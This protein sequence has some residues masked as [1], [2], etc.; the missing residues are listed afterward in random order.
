MVNK[1]SMN[2]YQPDFVTPPGETLLEVLESLTMT[3]TE[4]AER[5]GRPTKT[6]NEIIKGK[7]AL[8]PETALQFEKVLGINASFWNNREKQYRAF[9]AAQA[10][11]EKLLENFNWLRNI[12][13]NQM[14][15]FGWIPKPKEK[16][17]QLNSL[18]SFFGVAGP[19]QWKQIWSKPLVAYRESNVYKTKL[20]ALSA[21]LRCGELEAQKIRCN[22]FDRA[23]FKQALVEIRQLVKEREPE[24]FIPKLEKMCA[25]CGVAVVFIPELKGMTLSGATYWPSS[26]KA[27]IQLSLRYKTNDQLWF[28]FFHEAGHILLHKKDFIIENINGSDQVEQE[29]NNFAKNY[30]IPKKLYVEFAKIKPTKSRV[31]EFAKKI[32][33]DPAIVV[34]RLQHEKRIPFASNLN[35]LKISYRWSE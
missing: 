15:K 19:E 29:A 28:T 32:D 13:V 16:I 22:D 18:L 10:E 23:N 6:V 35:K 11:N 26:R 17:D 30:L 24:I 21:W 2:E 12:P 5:A 14:I 9:I 33:I 34:G 1:A 4:L 25:E 3:Q 20:G 8:T 7:T 27:V 31:L